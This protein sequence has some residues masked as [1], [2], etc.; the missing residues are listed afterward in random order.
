MHFLM[1]CWWCRFNWLPLLCC[2]HTHC[3]TDYDN[4]CC[5]KKPLQKMDMEEERLGKHWPPNKTRNV[6]FHWTEKLPSFFSLSQYKQKYYSNF[7]KATKLLGANFWKAGNNI[8]VFENVING[9]ICLIPL[10][11]NSVQF[12]KVFGAKKIFHFFPEGREEGQSKS[13]LSGR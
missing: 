4:I 6:V 2:A 1:V 13:R 9:R 10:Q 8:R 5:S 12:S 11:Q 7:A 3:S